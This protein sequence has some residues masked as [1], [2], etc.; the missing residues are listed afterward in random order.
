MPRGGGGAGRSRA[1]A[2]QPAAFAFGA[3]RELLPRGVQLSVAEF[4]FSDGF[5]VVFPDRFV[6]IPVAF[7]FVE[8][9]LQHLSFPKVQGSENR[10]FEYV[11]VDDHGG[12]AKIFY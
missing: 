4:Q 3:L 2:Y 8:P 5:G 10:F 11:P 12:I 9:P 6:E 7:A 1:E